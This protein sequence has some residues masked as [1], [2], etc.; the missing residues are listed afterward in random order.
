MPSRSLQPALPEDM[1][2]DP[3]HFVLGPVPGR[4]SVTVGAGHG[5]T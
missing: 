1:Y 4:E 3:A 2:V 5:F